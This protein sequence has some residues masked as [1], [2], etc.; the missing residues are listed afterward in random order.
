MRSTIAHARIESI[1]LDEAR[2]APG[3]VGVFSHDDLDLAPMP[4]G[5]PLLNQEMLRPLLAYGVVR[6]VGE[7]I[8]AIVAETPG[9]GADAAELR[10]GRLRPAACRRRS[11]GGPQG[12]ASSSTHR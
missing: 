10:R 6:Y 2:H 12:R 9:A 8:V 7:A 11:A 5:M 4:P 3:V 1:D